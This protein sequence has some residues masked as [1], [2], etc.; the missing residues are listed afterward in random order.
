[1]ANCP[2]HEG[3]VIRSVH[4]G[5][6]LLRIHPPDVSFLQV[7]FSPDS[8]RL[9]TVGT[10]KSAKV[11]DVETGELLLRLAGHRREIGYGVAYSPDGRLIATGA[12]DG[13]A[14]VWD[15]H[16]GRELLT[17]L[18]DPEQ[19]YALAGYS[20][21]V[22]WVDFDAKGGRLITG[23]YGGKARIWDLATGRLVRTF[24]SGGQRLRTIALFLPDQR[25]ILTSG[26]ITRAIRLWEASSGRLVAEARGR[27]IQSDL[28]VSADAGRM[29]T[30]SAE[31]ASMFVV[32]KG[33]G[34]LE[35]WDIDQSPRRILDLSGSEAFLT[36]ALTPDGRTVA[37]GSYD[38]CVHRW[39]S[40]PWRESEYAEMNQ[41]RAEDSGQ[42]SEVR[43]QRSEVGG[44]NDLSA[45]VRAYAR[46]YWR[47]R[48]QAEL[49]GAEG[50]P[51]EPRVIEVPMDRSLFAKRDPRATASQID[52]TAFYTGVLGETFYGKI[53][54]VFDHEDDLSG[55]PTGLV[56]LGGVE[57]DIRGVIQLRRAEPLDS[58]SEMAAADDPV[59]VDGIFIQQ[60][61]ARL[62]LLLG[63]IQS[64]GDGTVIGNLILHYADGETR[65]L[66]IVYGRD[67]R[68]WWCDPANGDTETTERAQV[69]WTGTNPVANERGQRLWLYLNTRE[70]PRPSV[71]ITTVDFVSAMTHSAPF[72]IAVT[73]E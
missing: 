10:Q 12:Y 53:W 30:S 16:T 24:D 31:G 38:S 35:V 14:K 47:D 66:D 48:L 61:T 20:N 49:K 8:R 57:F 26:S 3:V 37:C 32:G 29:F 55:L 19:G 70:N 58:Y 6:E 1:M 45:R 46:R 50:E 23:S 2:W 11:W 41:E 34:I 64:E 43:S 44:Q 13:T 59:R 40:F 56:N 60:A 7:A 5:R 62:Y 68:E 25:R 4:T 28:A 18:M 36:V 22:P 17:L 63:T 65:S 52:L 33:R 67:V 15:A 42:K 27:D 69:V 72:L 73:T 9:V 51:A 21:A 71:G 39:E 54:T